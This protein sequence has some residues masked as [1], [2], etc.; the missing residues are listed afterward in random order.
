MSQRL[1]RDECGQTQILMSAV[2]GAA[3]FT[4][5]LY[6]LD[7]TQRTTALQTKSVR[8]GEIRAALDVAIKHA[9]QIYRNE[10]GCDPVHLNERLARIQ[11]DG[12][13]APAPETVAT[14]ALPSFPPAVIYD[15]TWTRT[16]DVAI[17]GTDYPVTFGPVSQ[18]S[19]S[20][21]QNFVVADSPQGPMDAMVEVWTSRSLGP[22][23]NDGIRVAQRA[24]LINNCVY[25]CSRVAPNEFCPAKSALSHDD[26]VVFHALTGAD[27]LPACSGGRRVGNVDT[28]GCPAVT[29][30]VDV[31]DLHILRNHIRSGALAGTCEGLLAT[32]GGPCPAGCAAGPP[33]RSCGDL[34]A[35]LLVDEI[36]LNILEKILRGYLN[37]APVTL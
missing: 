15:T 16:M 37:T 5:A 33:A 13:L 17:S 21:G 32:G 36:D 12:S 6:S 10:A 23:P 18:V 26:G 4:G 20:D 30:R 24:V 7:Y 8:R 28:L 29:N 9:A 22:G 27:S 31:T 2:I 34:N 14:G 35:D 3:L 19:R 1:I 25:L 11:T